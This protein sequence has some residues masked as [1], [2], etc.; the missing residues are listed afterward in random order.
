VDWLDHP[1]RLHY[2]QS[3][4][5]PEGE[6]DD[7]LD[8]EELESWIIGSQELLGGRVEEEEG[9]EGDRDADVVDQ[10][11]VEIALRHLPSA[12][13]VF[14]PSL[15]DDDND[16]ED[17]LEK[18]E[19]EGS[20][21]AKPQKTNVVALS[22]QAACTRNITG[23]YMLS[24]DLCHDVALSTKV[25]IAQGEKVVDDKGLITVPD[26]VKVNIV[27]VGRE[28][29]EGKPGDKSIQRHNEEYPHN[30][31]LLGWICVESKVLVDLVAGYDDR[32]PHT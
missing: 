13:V 31:S 8:R 23:P 1:T 7:R 11:G 19:L 10:G 9:E 3:H 14:A 2:T 28:E 29:E 4:P 27:V 17:R 5:L 32:R 30:P 16:A 21:L 20:L 15:Q 26:G 25:L 12:L 22:S 18:A 6:K 24:P